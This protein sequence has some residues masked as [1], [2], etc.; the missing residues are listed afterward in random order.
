MIRREKA[1][2]EIGTKNG[3]KNEVEGHILM[4]NIMYIMASLAPCIL[5]S[6]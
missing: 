3:R 4:N 5:P 1:I 2:D 6:K